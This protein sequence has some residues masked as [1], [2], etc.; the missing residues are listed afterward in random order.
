MTNYTLTAD[1]ISRS[2][3]NGYSAD[4]YI[5]VA[6][7]PS[8][9]LRD[10][11]GNEYMYGMDNKLR[12]II[13]KGK[14]KKGVYTGDTYQGPQF[15]DT[16]IYELS[17]QPVSADKYAECVAIANYC[18]DFPE[19]EMREWVLAYAQWHLSAMRN[20]TVHAT[21]NF[22]KIDGHWTTYPLTAEQPQRDHQTGEVLETL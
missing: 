22:G 3:Y 20:D 5:I 11:D 4:S 18:G 13:G 8:E 7:L 17:V 9:I 15:T 12:A 6:D 1:D 16:R 21:V 2:T 10:L 14:I 19:A